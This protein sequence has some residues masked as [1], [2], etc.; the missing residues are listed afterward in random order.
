MEVNQAGSLRPWVALETPL[1]APGTGSPLGRRGGIEP[2]IV[3]FGP[4]PGQI[5]AQNAGDSAPTGAQIDFH[6]LS[7]SETISKAISWTPKA[8][9]FFP[10]PPWSGELAV[11][12]SGSR[13]GAPALS[14]LIRVASGNGH[15]VEALW[16]RR[17][18]TIVQDTRNIKPSARSLGL[19]VG[20]LGLLRHIFKAT[21]ENAALRRDLPSVCSPCSIKP[22]SFQPRGSGRRA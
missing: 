6:R 8:S 2:E 9:V 3:D 7:A 17:Q 18:V 5:L 12:P 19:L 10:S 1:T 15:V 4:L 22:R 11:P 13:A 21:L 20:L 14:A 16:L